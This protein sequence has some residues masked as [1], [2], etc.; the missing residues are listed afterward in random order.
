MAETD[1]GLI[2]GAI[3]ITSALTIIFSVVITVW[4]DFLIVLVVLLVVKAILNY[5]KFPTLL[6][7][8]AGLDIVSAVILIL[9]YFGISNSLFFVV[10]IFQL[11][12]GG[13]SFTVGI[14]S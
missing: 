4:G 12:K 8:M 5:H 1:T 10:G 6:N 7:P 14:T 3:D 9:L 11:L 13:F 2:Y